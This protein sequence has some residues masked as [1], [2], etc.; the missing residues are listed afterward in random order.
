M[1]LRANHVTQNKAPPR[2][3]SG[4]PN[5]DQIRLLI[6]VLAA[7]SGV[8]L[9]YLLTMPFLASLTWA[10]VLSVIFSPAHHW[11]ESRLRHRTLAALI[12]AIAIAFLVA[13][14]VAFVAQQLAGE[15]ANGAIYLEAT[16]RN[17]EWRTALVGHP[18][19][20]RAVLWVEQQLDLAGTAGSIASFLTTLGTSA[21]RS[22]AGQ[23]INVVLTFY[24]LFFFL[25]DKQQIVRKC[26]H[27]RP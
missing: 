5:A 15:T 23:V 27:F 21:L 22:S 14:P 16:L 1:T 19:V 10:L 9:C 3:E 7:G 8:Y 6:V 17:G 24:L 26:T 2:G 13:L 11:I 20:A 25:R 4:W 12:A 18:T